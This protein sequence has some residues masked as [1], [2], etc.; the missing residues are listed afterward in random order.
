M[1]KILVV[2]DDLSTQVALTGMLESAGH[3]VLAVSDGAQVKGSMEDFAPD[4]LITDILMPDKEG[5]ETIQDVRAAHPALPI[6]ALT[7]GGDAAGGYADY[8]LSCARD[9]GATGA[10]RK[11]VDMALLLAVV[12]TALEA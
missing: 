4:V 5:L 7:G 9:F 2:D 8:L 6:I 3:E 12:D 11:P 1:A 10:L